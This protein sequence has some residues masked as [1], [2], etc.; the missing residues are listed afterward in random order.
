MAAMMRFLD[1][2]EAGAL[3]F[4]A[5]FVKVGDV[6]VSQ[7]ANILAFLAP[8][9]GP[10]PAAGALRAEASQIQPTIPAFVDEI[11][12]P[13]TPT[14]GSRYYEDQKKEGQRRARRFARDG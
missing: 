5:P 4:A 11:P 12:D 2:E 7:T 8:R 3:P 9:L 1:G 14:D 13:T 6:V 10:V